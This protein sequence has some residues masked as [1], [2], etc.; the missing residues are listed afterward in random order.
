MYTMEPLS[1]QNYIALK[2]SIMYTGLRDSQFFCVYIYMCTI[3]GEKLQ[4]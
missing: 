4:I 2:M 1:Q 3:A